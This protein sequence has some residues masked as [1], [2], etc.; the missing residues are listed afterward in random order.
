MFL[1]IYQTNHLNLTLNYIVYVA[2]CCKHLFHLICYI[3]MFRINP[4][5]SKELM[6]S[7]EFMLTHARYLI[8]ILVHNKLKKSKLTSNIIFFNNRN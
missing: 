4:L 6:T 3:E 8:Y 1:G 7:N 5:K 2:D